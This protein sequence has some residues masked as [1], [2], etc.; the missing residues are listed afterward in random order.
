MCY[1]DGQCNLCRRTTAVLR[2]LDWLGR[3]E[4][5]DMTTAPD[6]PVPIEAAMQGMPMSTSSGRV[7]I[8]FPAVRRA[9]SQTPLGLPLAAILHLPGVSAVGAAT[10]RRIAGSRRRC[11]LPEVRA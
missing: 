8:G 5:R 3:L 6:L 7:L 4:F 11:P 1:Y 2:A 10:Y 9:L